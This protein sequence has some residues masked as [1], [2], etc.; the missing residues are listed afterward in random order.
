MRVIAVKAYEV[1]EQIRAR[2]EDDAKLKSKA[3]YTI[4]YIQGL[5]AL[6]RGENEN[7][8]LCRGESS[9]I[10]PISPSAVHTHPEG[11]RLAIKHFTEYLE[12]FPDDARARWLMNVAHMTLGEHSDRVDPRFLIS[13]DHFRKNEFDIGR[14]RDIG[15]K[16]GVNAFNQ[17]GGSI[18]DDFDRDGLLDLATST[19][20]PMG[21]MN[22]YRDNASGSFDKMTSEA[23]VSGQYGGLNCVQTDYNNDGFLDIFIIRGAWL[24]IPMRPSLTA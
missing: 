6:R 3:L 20:D 13:L 1:L 2:L 15:H 18:M 19:F 10:I 22:I 16:I 4:I 14:F 21:S 11:S 12:R 5:T 24:T 9:C 8:I 17:S 7:C 23:A